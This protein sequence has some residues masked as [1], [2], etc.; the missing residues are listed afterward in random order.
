MIGLSRSG[1][2]IKQRFV[3]IT[4]LFTVKVGF[5]M[6]LVA[7]T[8]TGMVLV[9]LLAS[10]VGC[11]DPIRKDYSRPLPEGAA[12]LEK[13][14]DPAQMPDLTQAFQGRDS[15]LLTAIDR[16][17]KWFEIPST[18]H[19]YPLQGFTH[20]QVHASVLAFRQLLQTAISAPDFQRRIREEFDFYR[21]VGWDGSGEV[22]FT[23]YY[24]PIFQAS[25]TRT[26][27][28]RFPIYSKPDDLI[29]EPITGEVKGRMRN[30]QLEP[31]PTRA[32]IEHFPERLG[33]V[34]KEIAW[35]KSQL[36]VYIVQVQGSAQLNLT[37]GTNMQVGYAASNGRDYVSLRGLLA[38]DGKIDPD[39]GGLPAIRA[40]FLQHP[41]E[42][43][44]Y[45]SR[46]ERFIFMKEYA[47]DQ[48]PAGSLGFKVTDFRSLATDKRIFPRAGVTLVVTQIPGG[49]STA[50]ARA[51]E[52]FMLD[53][54]TGGAIRA[55]GRADIYMGMGPQAEEVAGRQAYEGR[56]YYLILKPQRVSYWLGQQST[57]IMPHAIPAPR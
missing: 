14:T 52:Q 13:I 12:A 41:D 38:Q 27:E 35:M 29:V 3:S 26:Q 46:N 7:R 42:L 2:L 4:G 51:F 34:G 10:L 45:L 50:Q 20:E 15:S 31:Y 19:F 36:D 48:W 21:S 57:A 56:F 9:G 8:V 24:T 5:K 1:R 6:K 39:T 28:Y 55:P 22:L 43:S 11:H 37:D 40:Y 25:R 17:L 33:L 30:G 16:D 23:G 49:T 44:G 32:Q 53:Q 18:R 54:D 47:S